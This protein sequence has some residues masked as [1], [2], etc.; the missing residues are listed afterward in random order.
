MCKKADSKLL[1]TMHLEHTNVKADT[2]LSSNDKNPLLF[3][4]GLFVTTS[5][6]C[7]MITATTSA[8]KQAFLLL[9]EMLHA[10]KAV[11]AEQGRNNVNIG[12]R[13]RASLTST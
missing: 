6:K 4:I 13:S 7:N 8:H 10:Q 1:D 11:D 5:R 3:C 9:H 12:A 2:N